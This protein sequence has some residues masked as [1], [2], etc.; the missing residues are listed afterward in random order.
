M[1]GRTGS[2][3]AGEKEV[4][5]VVVNSVEEEEVVEVEDD[6]SDDDDDFGFELEELDGVGIDGLIVGWEDRDGVES[7]EEDTG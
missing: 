4:D 2:D 5:S 1:K 3:L 7:I 6:N